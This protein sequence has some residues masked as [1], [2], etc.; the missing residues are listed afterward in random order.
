VTAEG[1]EASGVGSEEATE[2]DEAA[3]EEGE[4]ASS[5]HMALQTLSLVRHPQIRITTH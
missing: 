1:V 3:D 4:A 5:P 2:V